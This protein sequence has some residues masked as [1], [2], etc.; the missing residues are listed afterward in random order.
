MFYLTRDTRRCYA[1]EYEIYE[2]HP[3]KDDEGNWAEHYEVGKL[4]RL[5][6]NAFHRLVKNVPR[7]RKGQCVKI[8][9]IKF[10]LDKPRK[11]RSK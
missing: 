10:V 4:T 6:R 7:L 1:D 11:R 5:C 9:E 2:G 3:V 8:K